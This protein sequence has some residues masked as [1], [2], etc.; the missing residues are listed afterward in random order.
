M[1]TSDLNGRM[2]QQRSFLLHAERLTIRMLARSDITEF[3]R[4]RY[5]DLSTL[6]D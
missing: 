2:A 5:L 1:S 6:P 3:T 4:Y